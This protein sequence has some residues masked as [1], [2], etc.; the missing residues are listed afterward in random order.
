MAIGL[1]RATAADEPLLVDL[2]HRYMGGMSE[3]FGI[4]PTPDGRFTYERLSL[5]FT[6]A[7]HTPFLIH[8]DAIVAGFALVSR[9][10]VVT[11]ASD[12][13]DLSE[14]YVLPAMRRRGIG[15]AAAAAVFGSFPG[16]WEVRAFDRSPGAIAFWTSA[17]TAHTSGAFAT[18]PWRS[19]PDRTWTVFRFV[20][21]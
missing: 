12:V 4:G 19:R 10:S 11:G 9:G 15:S 16:S 17:I 8:A 21:P 14:F 18:V 1:A 20:Q 13:H 6:D 2:L 3:V 5:Y 7:A